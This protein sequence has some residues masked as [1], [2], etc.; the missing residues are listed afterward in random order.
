MW[1]NDKSLALSKFCVRLFAAIGVGLCVG[2]PWLASFICNIRGA[3]MEGKYA[4]LLISV[5]SGAVFAFGA[6]YGLYRL[7]DNIGKGAA[8]VQV[9]IKY[10]RS[11]SWCCIGGGLICFASAFYYLPFLLI[12]V[13]AVFVG[14]ILRVV[15]NVFTDA[16]RIKDE[17][18][19]TI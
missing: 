10:L 2:M 17:N 16:V 7:L 19:F 13:M 8:F 15:K 12:S 4:L 14:L 1:N 11:I 6:L 9:N 3:Y 5:Y 18:D